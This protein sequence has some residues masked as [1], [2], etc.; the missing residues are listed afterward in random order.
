LP[1]KDRRI[2]EEE[3]RECNADVDKNNLAFAAMGIM[4]KK[5]SI[6]QSKPRQ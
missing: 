1:D 4:Q 5:D 2:K 3:D 6:K